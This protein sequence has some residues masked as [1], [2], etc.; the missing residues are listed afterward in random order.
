MNAS[1]LSLV[2][3]SHLSVPLHFAHALASFSLLEFSHHLCV[4]R[5]TSAHKITIKILGKIPFH[6]HE[7]CTKIQHPKQQKNTV[8]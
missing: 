5:K 3:F 4:K 6:L 7:L 2:H 1:M 8:P